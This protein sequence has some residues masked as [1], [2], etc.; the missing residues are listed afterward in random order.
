MEETFIIVALVLFGLILG[1]YAAATVWRLR[2]RQLVDDK[3]AG[4]K[5]DAKEYKRLLPLTKETTRSDRSRCLHCGHGLAWYDLLP[6]VSW[7]QLKGKCRYCR[8]SIGYF[9]PL[10]ELG[11][12]VVFVVSYLLWPAPLDTVLQIASFVLWL[13]AVVMLAIL[14]AYDMKWF[15]LPDQVVYPLVGVGLL[16][17]VIAVVSAPDFFAA[18]VDVSIGVVILSGVYLLLWLMSK[19]RWI[20]FGDV[21]LGLGLALILSSWQGAFI[22]LFAANL[23]GCLIVIPG[24]IS[25]KLTRT[26]QIP[27]GPLLILG[28]VIALL[29]GKSIIL[30]YSSLLI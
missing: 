13:V 17:A 20:G 6:L 4:E 22:A 9:E 21:K 26:T 12:G 14:F 1:S 11:V 18:I 24:M 15:L 27:F 3:A 30:W 10:M 28:C 25:G 2:A 19:G 16:M 23:L 8:K 5:V 29:T 7:L